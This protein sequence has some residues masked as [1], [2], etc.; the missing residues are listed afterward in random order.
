MVAISN[1][2]V[3]INLLPAYRIV[4]VIN[5]KIDLISKRLLK[6]NKSILPGKVTPIVAMPYFVVLVIFVAAASTFNQ[7]G[8]CASHVLKTVFLS[9]SPWL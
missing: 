8:A 7:L 4:S 5:I 6:Y 9:T 1:G 3:F 2:S